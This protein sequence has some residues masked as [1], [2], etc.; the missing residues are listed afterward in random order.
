MITLYG[1][2]DPN[3]MAGDISRVLITA[4]LGRAAAM[5]LF[6]PFLGMN[7]VFDV[8]VITLIFFIVTAFGASDRRD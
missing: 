7:S 5:G 1:A 3:M 8:V 4:L 6:D 2:G